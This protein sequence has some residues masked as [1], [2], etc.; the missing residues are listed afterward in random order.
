MLIEREDIRVF[1][2]DIQKK[3]RKT[4]LTVSV[5]LLVGLAVITLLTAAHSY[6][7]AITIWPLS[8]VLGWFI[9][10]QEERVRLN[11]IT[12]LFFLGP[13]YIIDHLVFKYKTGERVNYDM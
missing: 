4:T 1:P 5:L 11:H 2:P 10:L 8:W 6:L 7:W 3:H 9:V 12:G 13:I